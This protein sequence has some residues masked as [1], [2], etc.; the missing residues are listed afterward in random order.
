MR[1]FGSAI[2]DGWVV[3]CIFIWVLNQRC[4][5]PQL[6]VDLNIETGSPAYYTNFVKALRSLSDNSGKRYFVLTRA[7]SF[8]IWFYLAT[9]Y[10]VTAAPQC[11]F[12]DDK[13]GYALNHAWF[14]A[15]YVQFCEYWYP[16]L[17]NP[18]SDPVFHRQQFL[19]SFVSGGKYRISHS[20]R[21]NVLISILPVF[22]LQ[23]LVI[24]NLILPYLM[25]YEL[26]LRR[27]QWAKTKSFN[28][29]IKVYLGAPA[30]IGTDGHLSSKALITLARATQKNY[31]S[32]GGVMLWDADSAYCEIYVTLP[33]FRANREIFSKPKIPC[34]RE[35]CHQKTGMGDITS[36]GVVFLL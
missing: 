23:H 24:W 18:T 17:C 26:N 13:V 14:D 27:D 28:K 25:P 36:E 16:L 35:K 11:P 21:P 2:L 15:V 7:D 6:S 1:P 34:R 22:Q 12:P 10:Y 3:L 5:S 9:S 19:R 29:G 31:T 30:A 4:V 32:F 20:C 8:W 33:R